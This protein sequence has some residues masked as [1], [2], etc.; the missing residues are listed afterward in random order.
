MLLV[1]GADK[2][3][4]LRGRNAAVLAAEYRHPDLAAL[5]KKP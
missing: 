4:T 5:L 1:N 2:Q 3:A